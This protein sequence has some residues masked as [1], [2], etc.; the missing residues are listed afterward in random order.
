MISGK[1]T[2]PVPARCRRLLPMPGAILVAALLGT[3]AAAAQSGTDARPAAAAASASEVPATAAAGS[4]PTTVGTPEPEPALVA[5]LASLRRQPP[6]SDAFHELRYRRALRAPLHVSGE[7]V[8]QGD[9][10][11]VREVR[12]PYREHSRLQDGSL[13]Q[14]REGADERRVP[15]RR[16]P[17]LRVLFEGLAA[18][19]AGDAGAFTALF[20]VRLQRGDAGAGPGA[21]AAG[22]ADAGNG[23]DNGAWRLDLAPRDAGL[24]Q[25]V[26]ALSFH[27]RGHQAHCLVLHQRNAQTLIVLDAQPLPAA[28]AAAPGETGKAGNVALQA[29][30]DQLCPLPAGAGTPDA[31]P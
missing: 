3:T 19:F 4:G 26:P 23:A 9:M 27:G 21:D 13:V 6:V 17:E 12:Q 20:R 7:L 28:P 2:T 31:G 10:A 14:Q 29:R 24:R 15:L 8:W 16:A 5:L 18:L 11:F 30:I 22:A 25:R 1:T